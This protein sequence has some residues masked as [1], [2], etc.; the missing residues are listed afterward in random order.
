MLLR[1]LYDSARRQRQTLIDDIHN[2]R[3]CVWPNNLVTKANTNELVKK[4]LY[5][6]SNALIYA[7]RARLFD[8]DLRW[9]SSNIVTIF[10]HGCDKMEEEKVL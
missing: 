6:R 2:F 4:F 1:R 5:T 10:S 7:F 9:T 3:H 8:D